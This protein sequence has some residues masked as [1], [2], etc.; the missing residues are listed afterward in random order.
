MKEKTFTSV[1]SADLATRK[2]NMRR[3]VRISARRIIAV[4]WKS[5]F[6]R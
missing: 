6:M 3:N 2:K 1:L 4:L 5:Q